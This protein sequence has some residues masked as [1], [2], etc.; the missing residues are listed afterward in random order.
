MSAQEMRKLMESLK[1]SGNLG[2]RKAVEV[3]N[4][5]IENLEQVAGE[6]SDE[7]YSSTIEVLESFKEDFMNSSDDEIDCEMIEMIRDTIFEVS[8]GDDLAYNI[9]AAVASCFNLDCL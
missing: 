1:E 2:C 4:A 8:E 5:E 7:D 9:A 3:L 6:F